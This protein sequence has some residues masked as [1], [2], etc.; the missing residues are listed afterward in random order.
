MGIQST[1]HI[2]H[3]GAWE[4]LIGVARRILDA[5]LIRNH[6]NLTHEIL[7]TFMVEVTAIVNARPLT[8]ISYD[9]E[10]PCL[11]TPSLL[12]TQ[13]SS[14]ATF[15]IPDFG[16][17]DMLRSQWKHVQVLAEEF[18]QKWRSEYLHSLQP[19][20]KW[21]SDT[22]NRTVGTVVLMKDS[23]CARNDWPIGIV[24]REFP[25]DDGR[26]RKVDLKVVRNGKT[27]TYIRPITELVVLLE[28]Q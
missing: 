28:S 16:R 5:M 7:S 12:L 17:K 22:Q 3:G 14:P 25:G 23:A 2:S 24:K 20:K 4:R 11:L 8:T 1:S 9:P 15:P 18:W 26:V 21:K 27:T 19:R 13:K 6:G 10:S